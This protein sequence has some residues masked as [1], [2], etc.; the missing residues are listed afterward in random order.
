M[1]TSVKHH[2]RSFLEVMVINTET[3]SQCTGVTQE[4]VG[5]IKDQ[6]TS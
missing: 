1:S 6:R 5:C 2:Q 3:F 4:T